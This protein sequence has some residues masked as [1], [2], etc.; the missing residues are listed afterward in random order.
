MKLP[1]PLR[2]LLS[3]TARN[4]KLFLRDKAAVFFSFLSAIIMV[5]LYFL[6]IAK[7]Y[8]SALAAAGNFGGSAAQTDFLV[9]S[10]MMAGVLVINSI[11]L[12]LGVFGAIAKDFE[13][14]RVDGFLLTPLRAREIVAAYFLGG[15]AVSF[16][17]NLLTWAAS[18]A[19]IGALTGY[20]FGAG[21]FFAAVGILAAASLIG[22]SIM[23][24]ITALVRSVAALNVV[25]GVIGTFLGFLCGIYMPYSNLGKGAEAVGSLLPFT[26]LTVWLK[27]TVLND[28][29]TQLSV[30]A[31]MQETILRD[32]FSAKSVGFCGIAAPLWVM[33][34]LSGAFALGCLAA[35]VFVLKR[36]I[37][38]NKK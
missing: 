2:P 1:R 26:H 17:L 3:L 32:Y 18:A 15:F 36:R 19:L 24:L 30:P 27:Q 34:L 9:Y 33:L 7:L 28:A 11:S 35:A 12:S 25:G 21:T 8:S 14:R 29:L 10:Q 37:G 20:W 16:A 13:G 31:D 23:L 6:F 5:A 4:V 22:S 38:G